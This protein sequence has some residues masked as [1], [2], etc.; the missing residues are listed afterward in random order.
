[1]IPDTDERALPHPSTPIK[2]IPIGYAAPLILTRI[3]NTVSV[4]L[5]YEPNGR[6]YEFGCNWDGESLTIIEQ[7]TG[8]LPTSQE[9]KDEY[10]KAKTRQLNP[11]IMPLPPRS[12]FEPMQ[13]KPY[14]SNPKPSHIGFNAVIF[15]FLII[16]S[17]VAVFSFL[18]GRGF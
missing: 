11:T 5:I 1:M 3:D 9:I 6:F 14:V 16:L 7:L 18:A 10:Y 4:R 17:F 15:L 12:K 2:D 13:P 8:P